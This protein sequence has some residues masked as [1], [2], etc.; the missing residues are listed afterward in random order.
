[1]MW[2]GR[3]NPLI[4]VDEPDLADSLIRL[5]RIDALY[6]ASDHPDVRAFIERY[7]H[8]PWPFLHDELIM[9]GFRGKSPIVVDLSYPIEKLYLE[10][11]RNNPQPGPGID[12]FKWDPDDPLADMLLLSYGGV[13]STEE[14]GPDYLGLIRLKLLGSD[15][16]IAKDTELPPP[17]SDRLT[18]AAVN[19]AYIDTHYSI[20]NHWSHAG[21]Y[22][23]QANCFDDL[24]TF[25]NL[26]ARP[27]KG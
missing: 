12:L 6:S 9:E 11:Y 7:P 15:I 18:L 16:A 22:I 14:V 5:F 3:F 8:L 13:P 10:G 25:W 19:E 26:R 27:E 1:M 17:H 21:I 23:G 20:R 4:P 24:V 2:G